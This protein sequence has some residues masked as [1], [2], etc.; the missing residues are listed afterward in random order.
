[1]LAKEELCKTLG[2]RC[3]GGG[4][5]LARDPVLEKG[6]CLVQSRLASEGKNNSAQKPANQGVSEIYKI[7]RAVWE[8]KLILVSF[9]VQE[10]IPNNKRKLHQTLKKYIGTPNSQE[11][12]KMF[13]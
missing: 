10:L 2:E 5:S 9:F 3:R 1:M 4:S 6:Q 8:N 7:L 12:F 13:I 11:I